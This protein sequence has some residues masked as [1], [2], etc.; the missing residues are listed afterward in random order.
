MSKTTAR[1]ASTCAA[2]VC[3]YRLGLAA[4][5]SALRGLSCL[6]LR[7]ASHSCVSLAFPS[8]VRPPVWRTHAHTGPELRLRA[9]QGHSQCVAE[10]ID[11]SKLLTSITRDSAPEV[12]VHGTYRAVLPQIMSDGLKVRQ[13]HIHNPSHTPRIHQRVRGRGGRRIREQ[14]FAA[15]C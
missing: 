14:C 7:P 8:L 13:K 11:Q 1:S 10:R 12:C 15:C 9:S 3:F 4:G 5:A 2:T 6:V